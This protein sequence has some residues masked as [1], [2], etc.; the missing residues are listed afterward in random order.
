M[1]T[2]NNIPRIDKPTENNRSGSHIFSSSPSIGHLRGNL[3]TQEIN[4]ALSL[5]GQNCKIYLT[6]AF[7]SLSL[8]LGANE[9]E[10]VWYSSEGMADGVVM[11]TTELTCSLISVLLNLMVINAL[12]NR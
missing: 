7:I 11:V 5:D 4:L 12:R 9:S 6:R 10:E 8:G 1:Y 2:V 3:S